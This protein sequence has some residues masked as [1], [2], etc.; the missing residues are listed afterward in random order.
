MELDGEELQ[1][2][3]LRLTLL[4]YDDY[5]NFNKNKAKYQNPNNP[6]AVSPLPDSPGA[7]PDKRKQEAN[8]N[9]LKP[10]PVQVKMRYDQREEAKVPAK[11]EDED[12]WSQVSKTSSV[13]I[14]LTRLL[15]LD[16]NI[17]RKFGQFP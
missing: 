1:L 13:S 11:A 10:Q 6:A 9:I 3:K 4:N 17:A 5:L 12:A 15:Y 14:V 16:Q 7:K 8:G 2:K